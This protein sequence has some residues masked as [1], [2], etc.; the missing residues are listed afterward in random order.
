MTSR[1]LIYREKETARSQ[2]ILRERIERTVAKAGGYL[3]SMQV[4]HKSNPMRGGI[5]RA[6]AVHRVRFTE[7]A[8]HFN[9][10]LNEVRMDYVADGLLALMGYRDLLLAQQ[11]AQGH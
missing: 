3:Q 6:Y 2:S 9:A 7:E 10:R 5:T 8:M 4:T 1:L 11:S